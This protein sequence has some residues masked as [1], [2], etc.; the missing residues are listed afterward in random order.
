MGLRWTAEKKRRIRESR[1]TATRLLVQAL[2]RLAKPPSVLVCASGIGYYGSRGDGVLTE[3][4]RPG[5]GF[6]ADLGRDWEAATAIAHGIRVV[7]LRFGIVLS[8]QGGA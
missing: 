8:A 1:V 2:T 5:T 4:S 6:L 7:N 3:D